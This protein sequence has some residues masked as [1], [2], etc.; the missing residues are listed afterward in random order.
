MFNYIISK[1]HGTPSGAIFNLWQKKN[2]PTMLII[3]SLMYL[4]TG[5]R[6]RNEA[7]LIYPV[8]GRP[9]EECSPEMS[10]YKSVQLRTN[11]QDP[12][13]AL[14]VAISG[15][16]HRA[17]NFTAGVMLGLEEV[18][19]HDST[20]NN[21]LSQVDYFSTVSGGGFAIAAYISTLHDYIYFK[22]TD[23]DYSFAAA[24]RYPPK[25][26]PPVNCQSGCKSTEHPPA[27]QLTDP[28]IT[29]ALQ[30][31]YPE[32]LNK[33]LEEVLF[34]MSLGKLGKPC[35]LEQAI[36]NDL[37]GYCWRK[38]KLQS[39]A[40]EENPKVSLTF[41]DLFIRKNDSDA[42]VNLPYWV[43]NATAYEN[44]AI[45]AFTPDFL[46]LYHITGYKHRSKIYKYDSSKE[47]YDEFIWNVPLS[48]GVTAS[49]NFP[50]VV[51]ATTLNSSMDPNNPYLHLLDG[52]M[53]E[54]LGVITAL[55]LLEEECDNAVTKKVLLAI[56]AYH[57]T[58]APF[59]EV[60]YSPRMATTTV[61]SMNISLD[62]WHGRHRQIVRHLCNNNNVEV[63]FLSF[64]DLD[65]LTSCT[66]LFDF[67]LE[68]N[69]VKELTD[70]P[71]HTQPFKLL[72]AIPTVNFK[73]KGMLSSAQ[74]N[75][76]FA[77][78]RYIAHKN[79][80]EILQKLSW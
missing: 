1:L 54:N 31:F 8:C 17:A 49:G 67:G 74:Q 21:I 59:S 27:D 52:G 12:N 51:P 70:Q 68:P 14:A 24:L 71:D 72:R 11:R 69:D 39:S 9:Y 36:D 35:Q 34:G 46:S 6:T 23:D 3:I 55:R 20:R 43:A 56:D 80:D 77:A 64:A 65:E 28:C 26:W 62:S 13:L 42:Q 57:G 60:N 33:F 47:N 79:K 30:G 4:L 2:K 58:F 7:S 22:G 78:G 37:L 18:S 10:A 41:N 32:F 53:A 73:K 38:R 40:S 75:L 44:G 19:N 76:L 45:F 50:V 63:V 15:G 16:G 48:L 5:C 29:R 61:R 25:D 66:A